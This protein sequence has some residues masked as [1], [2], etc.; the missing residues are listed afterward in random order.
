MQIPQSVLAQYQSVNNQAQQTA[1]TPFQ[2]YGGE[3]VAPVNT[4]QTSGIAGTNAYANTAQPYYGAA[5]SGL[6][7]TQA[8]T[9]PVNQAAEYG[10]AASASPLTGS[11][12]ESYLSPYLNTVEGSTSALLNQEN[13]QQQA[14]QL[15]N[16]ITSGAFGSDR[17]GIAAA[18]LAQ[19]EE[20]AN[21]NVLSGIANTGYQSALGTAQGQQQIGLAGANQLA[22][23]GSTAYGEGANTAS[24][25]A[26]L[27][28][29]AQA[30]G[31][32]G[33]QAQI[34][35]GTVQQQT[36]Q[37]QDTAEYNQF[38]QQQSYPF[39]VD[40]FLANIAEGT[41]S[42]SGSTTTTTQPGGFFS[43][44]R[45]KD[46][47]EPIGKTF[48]GQTIYRYRMGGDPRTRIGL[49]AQKVEKK[50]PAA[51]GLA[52][53]FKWV[54][55]GKATDAAANRGHMYTGGIARAPLAERRA[56][57]YGGT[58]DDS[59][60]GLGA[61]LAAQ[62]N[63]YAPGTASQTQRNVGS[64]ATQAHQLA[65]ASGS[66]PPPAS[67]GSG[68]QQ[69][70]GLGKDAYQ[71][72]KW[73]NKPSSTP[74]TTPGGQ[75]V[76]QNVY[77]AG[78]QPGTGSPPPGVTTNYETAYSPGDT[79][80]FDAGL[81]TAPSSGVAAP[82]GTQGL[83]AADL[84]S[85]APSSAGIAAAPTEVAGAGAE[86][87]GSAAAE[88][89]A[90]AGADIAG[91]AAAEGAAGAAAGAGA[92]AGADAAAALA[93]EYAAADIGVAA[94]AAA[95]R[96]GRIRQNFDA[97][98]TP[99]SDP[100]S[101]LD[102]PD[103]SA[104]AYKLQTAGP[105]Q[106][107]PTGLQSAMKMGDPTQLSSNTG[108]VFSNQ[109]LAAGGRARFADGGT[110]AAADATEDDGQP[111]PADIA[112]DTARGAGLANNASQS[113]WWSRLKNSD[114]AKPQNF[115]PLLSGLAAMG[116]AKTV[117]PGVALAA[118]LG[119][120]AQS[121][122]STQATSAD[123][124]RTQAVT[125]GQEISNQLNAIKTQAVK[126]ALAGK[127]PG[128]SS[129][130]ASPIGAPNAQP[131]GTDT[132][133]S[134]LDAKY[135]SRFYTQPYTQDE[136]NDIARGNAL[137]AT[138]GSPAWAAAAQQRRQQRYDNQF[139]ANQSAA[140]HEADGLYE[141]ATK[142]PDPTNRQAAEASYNAIHQWTGDGYTTDAGGNK[143]INRTGAPAIGVARQQLAPSG[144]IVSDSYGN[145]FVWNKQ[146]NTLKPIGTGGVTKATTGTTP[147]NNAP[148][149]T[150]SPSTPV[151]FQQPVAGQDQILQDVENAR[152]VGDQAPINRNINQ[153][154]LQLSSETKT[155]PG[156]QTIS[157][158][159]GV[160]NLPQGANYQ[161]IN[162][163]LDRQAA[164]SARQMG[165]PHTN[166]GLAASQSATGTTEYVP[167]ALQEKVKFADALN[168]G[169][170]GYR[171]AQDKIIGTGP[172]PDL[173]KYQAFRAAWAKNFD[174]DIMRAEDAIRRGDND[175]LNSLRKR[176]G[177]SGMK[178]LHQKSA[179]LRLLEN[180]T[181]PP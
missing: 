147:A 66:P 62:R 15:G 110:P 151:K 69:A 77:Q 34:A 141:V 95:K 88:G 57:A 158:L 4:E 83:G 58:P 176:L 111:T 163:Y 166:A 92:E 138:T 165:V 140:Q 129:S 155:G 2:T 16:A 159:A 20:L 70:V 122:L 78:L 41:G 90:G 19:Q 100:D 44:E 126:D 170:I 14:G 161:D 178:T 68:A 121:Y 74:T 167:A 48:D 123:I 80:T 132:T 85:A 154:L 51:V 139:A 153:H 10:T 127:V 50:H 174:P 169:A 135:R 103:S 143:T 145:K 181:I 26:S 3:F 75:G 113:S 52:G 106:K 130:S 157:K 43:D 107:Q 99:Y 27:G 31:L 150:S 112:T 40:Q 149:K 30:A 32:S 81:D 42:L 29:G 11:Q 39:Q 134:A 128:A 28:S 8:A 76:T 59:E 1:S 168:S 173:T 93:A 23:I 36:Q 101:S 109:G 9:N 125:R 6:A 152:A 108:Q 38:L 49:S 91:T 162:A 156:T 175:E 137:S 56:Y 118:G 37:A 13:Q 115:V 54:D 89:A 21:A 102:I 114:I 164:L 64:G 63:M 131:A 25:L 98:G 96:G 105:I 7:G 47:M 12:I 53:G 104:S 136:I 18:N 60:G 82:G 65:V 146:T 177:A 120:G 171:Q 97:G 179:N 144:D 124:A 33:A 119:A 84:S 22:S 180:G 71:G 133:A 148:A 46:D 67:R 45:L 87:A 73:L 79:T 116:T 35:A 142:D 55:Y 24:E 17:T 5:T 72:Y 172:T 61:V 117:H 94:L 86:A 160:L